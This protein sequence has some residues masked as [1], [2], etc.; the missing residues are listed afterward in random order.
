MHSEYIMKELRNSATTTA[1]ARFTDKELRALAAE[2]KA[3]A[4]CLRK[5]EER[6]LMTYGI[7]RVADFDKRHD[8][9][10]AVLAQRALD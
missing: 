2:L 5:I 10:T 9:V 4:N 8:L 3:K 1:L 6:L 7:R